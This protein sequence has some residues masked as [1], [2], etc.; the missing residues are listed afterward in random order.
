[1]LGTEDRHG[2]LHG[3]T[4]NRSSSHVVIKAQRRHQGAGTSLGFAG[5]RNAQRRA[6]L[7]RLD[8]KAAAQALLDLRERI[9]GPEFTERVL[10]ET[11]TRAGRNPDVVKIALAITLSIE[12]AQA[13]TPDPVYGCPRISSSSWT[14]PSSPPLPCIATIHIGTATLAPGCAPAWDRRPP[15]DLMAEPAQW[16]PRHSAPTHADSRSSERRP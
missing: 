16:R 2:D 6:L 13:Y 1:M 12:R 5:H 3:P 11:Q 14:V 8:D 9:R 7:G 4:T 15:D 10:A